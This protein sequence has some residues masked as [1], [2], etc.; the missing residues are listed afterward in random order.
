MIGSEHRQ[1][2]SFFPPASI[3]IY[4]TRDVV[5]HYWNWSA[6]KPRVRAH[7]LGTWRNRGGLFGNRPPCYKQKCS[8]VSL[9]W[10]L[11]LAMCSRESLLFIAV[12]E[13]YI[14][15]VRKLLSQS[16]HVDT[17]DDGRRTPL[18][19][20]CAAG[21]FEI[22]QLLLENSANVH[23]EDCVRDTPL[24]LAASALRNSAELVKLLIAAGANV[25]HANK[26]D[27]TALMDAANSGYV[28]TIKVLIA[29]GADLYAFDQV[30][31]TAL[32]FAATRGH[33]E[34]I[35]VLLDAGMEVDYC[36]PSNPDGAT[37]LLTAAFDGT[38]Q[39][40]QA[41]L[42]GGADRQ[43]RDC[44]QRTALQVA[45]KRNPEPEVAQVLKDATSCHKIP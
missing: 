4:S 15:E 5:C 35:R 11:C 40:V 16:I 14:A 22:A 17:R 26:F 38:P 25:A 44:K 18:H 2:A 27:W 28:D 24:S 30:G 32:H 13:G 10:L 29:A 20:A 31:L 8:L 23:A 33:A 12:R 7:D 1:L 42:D 41:L 21:E 3:A 34:C 9:P 45:R 36:G 43:Q 6:M 39:V 19:F 37:A